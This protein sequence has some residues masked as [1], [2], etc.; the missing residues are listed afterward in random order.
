MTMEPI[1]FFF[2]MHP[3]NSQLHVYTEEM[4]GVAF[5]NCTDSRPSF[6]HRRTEEVMALK[7][8]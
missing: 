4:W 1:H 8:E 7:P 3:A 5:A 2:D 6:P